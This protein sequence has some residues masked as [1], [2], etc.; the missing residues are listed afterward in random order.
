MENAHRQSF[1]LQNLT[2]H[3]FPRPHLSKPFCLCP[4]DT[5]ATTAGR[6]TKGEWTHLEWTRSL[7]DKVRGCISVSLEATGAK[8][9]IAKGRRS[10]WF[11]GNQLGWLMRQPLVFGEVVG[12]IITLLPKA[13]SLGFL[14]LCRLQCYFYHLPGASCQLLWEA[15]FHFKAGVE[16][17]WS[18]SLFFWNSLAFSMIQRMLAIWSLLPRPF[19]KPAWTSRSSWFTYCWSLAWRILSITLLACEM[20][21]IVR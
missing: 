4:P 1:L 2:F 18:D 11:W 8:M 16:G 6:S 17:R 14:L 19:L 9:G 10:L 20:S 5:V 3:S 7:G 15:L 21:A 12:R 13:E